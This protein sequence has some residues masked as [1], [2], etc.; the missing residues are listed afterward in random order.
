M[1]KILAAAGQPLPQSKPILEINPDH[2]LVR[3]LEAE[4]DEGRF[5]DLSIVLFD[6]ATLAEGGDLDDPSGFVNIIN[7][8]LTETPDDA[9]PQEDEG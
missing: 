9:E 1:R 4:Q 8:L 7:R 6:Q 5:G 3:K 2:R